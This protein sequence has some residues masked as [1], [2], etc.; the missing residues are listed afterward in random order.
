LTSLGCRDTES[1]VLLVI[2]PFEFRFEILEFNQLTR[3]SLLPYYYGKT[4]TQKEGVFAMPR[5]RKR[6]DEL[7]LDQRIENLEAELKEL[8]ETVKEKKDELK[9]LL[10]EKEA[11][12][13]TTL[14]AAVRESGKTVEEV[15]E[16]LKN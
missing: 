5:G 2:I 13:I 16:M 11:E 7:T 6:K 15:L 12:Q 4:I 3:T 10:K 8:N 14:M 9:G 1:C